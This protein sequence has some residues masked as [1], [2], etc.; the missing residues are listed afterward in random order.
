MPHRWACI[1]GQP[2]HHSLSPTLHNAAFVTGKGRVERQEGDPPTFTAEAISL[3]HD[4]PKYSPVARV[5]H[6]HDA[7]HP[8]N[9]E[10]TTP[11]DDCIHGQR[12]C[13]ICTKAC[14]R[15]RAWEIESDEAL[16]G[17]ART[18]DEIVRQAAP[19]FN[20]AL[21][22]DA[23]AV[24]KQWKDRGGTAALLATVRDAL[25]LLPDWSAGAMED[26]LRALAERLGLG[27]KAGRIFQPLRMKESFC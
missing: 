8:F 3:G 9:T 14:P 26:A 15:F 5:R 22:F 10:N 2:I 6:E 18:V 24:A 11:F 21:E 1:F 23:D 25:A 4:F 19:F 27:D 17:R 13:D 7:Y 16:F 20:D 12:G